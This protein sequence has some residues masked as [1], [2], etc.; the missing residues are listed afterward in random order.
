MKIPKSTLRLTEQK[1]F[2]GPLGATLGGLTAG[3]LAYFSFIAVVPEADDPRTKTVRLHALV[4]LI[5]FLFIAGAAIG[6]TGVLTGRV[7]AIR[8]RFLVSCGIATAFGL[9]TP[10]GLQGAFILLGFTILGA[11]SAALVSINASRLFSRHSGTDSK[12][13][14][15]L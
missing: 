11:S 2:K 15:L 9:I 6:W 4:N 1:W 10:F 12:N 7:S 5:L 3:I 8:K 14:A 13:P